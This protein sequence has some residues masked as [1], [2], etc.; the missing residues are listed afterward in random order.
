[1]VGLVHL[2][3]D[4]FERAVGDRAQRCDVES[5]YMRA[6]ALR[7]RER[8]R[9]R[10]RLAVIAAQVHEDVELSHDSILHSIPVASLRFGRAARSVR[11]SFA[12]TRLPTTPRYG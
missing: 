8:D 9:R 10:E 7:E 5:E 3:H 1:I 2:E 12:S 11:A 6:Q 4:G